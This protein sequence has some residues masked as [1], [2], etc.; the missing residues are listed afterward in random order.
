M[1]NNYFEEEKEKN[2]LMDKLRNF[3]YYK[4]PHTSVVGF[5]FFLIIPALALGFWLI[6]KSVDELNHQISILSNDIARIDTRLTKTA[7]TLENNIQETKSSLNEELSKEKQNIENKFSDVQNE[8]KN[9]SGDVSSLKKLSET[10][11]ELLQKYSKVFFLNEHYSPPRLTEIPNKY[12]YYEER[13]HQIHTK[14]WPFLKNMLNSADANGIKLYVYSAYRS[15]DTQEALKGQYEII[16]G[17]GTAN[18]FSADQGYSEHQLGTTVDL[19]TTGINGTLEGLGSTNAYKWLKEN[20]YKFGFTLSYPK[21]NGYFVYEPWHWRFVGVEL[22]NDLKNQNK[23]FYDL[24]QREI[25]EY[26]IS[27]FD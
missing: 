25:D 4:I 26:L 6:F 23:H 22:A 8:V 3:F 20:A 9:V 12:K 2:N 17:E 5:L 18:K 21:G 27:I 16:Y 14:I 11:P 15:F 24:T 7:Q 10:D 19:I 13:N 1:K